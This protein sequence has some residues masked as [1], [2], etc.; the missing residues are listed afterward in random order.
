VQT[1]T[2]INQECTLVIIFLLNIRGKIRN[3]IRHGII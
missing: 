1:L 2:T 3:M